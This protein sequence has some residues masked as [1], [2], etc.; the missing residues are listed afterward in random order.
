MANSLMIKSED[1]GGF[2]LE[3]DQKQQPG[4][5]GDVI[6]TATGTNGVLT[7][8]HPPPPGETYTMPLKKGDTISVLPVGHLIITTQDDP[9]GLRCD[10]SEWAA[11]P[12]KYQKHGAG[13]K[14]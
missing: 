6:Y 14:K 2:L 9:S 11:A 7:V 13:G 10:P 1:H 12:Q 5:S 4:E 8:F 3:G